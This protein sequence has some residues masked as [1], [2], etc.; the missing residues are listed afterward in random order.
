[1][2]CTYCEGCNSTLV[3]LTPKDNAA[4][5]IMMYHSAKHWELEG[6]S[7]CGSGPGV[8]IHFCPMC[9]EPLTEPQPLTLEELRESGMTWV[10][11]RRLG[12]YPISIRKYID[13]YGFV[14]VRNNH[15]LLVE[16][17]L[18]FDDYGKKWLAYRRPPKGAAP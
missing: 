18:S 1:M 10:W 17:R 7:N 16:L 12:D 5:D 15:V 3:Y 14:I 2:S 8:I 11:V 6:I 4:V 9:G 13:G